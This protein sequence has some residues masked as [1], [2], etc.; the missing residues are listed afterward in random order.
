MNTIV[1]RVREVNGQLALYPSMTLSITYDHRALDGA[2]ASRFLH[3]LCQ[4]LENSRC[5][6][7]NKEEGSPCTI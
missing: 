1:N 3:A 7:R 6:W 4:N 2:P 5:C